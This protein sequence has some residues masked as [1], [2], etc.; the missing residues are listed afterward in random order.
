MIRGARQAS[1]GAARLFRHSRRL[2]SNR[3]RNGVE[4]PGT[5]KQDAD[6]IHERGGEEGPHAGRIPPEV[7]LGMPP[8]PPGQRGGDDDDGENLRFASR[9][10]SRRKYFEELSLEVDRIVKILL[11]D[12]PGFSARQALDEMNLRVSNELVRE[13]LSRIVVSVDSVNRERFPRLA[14]KFFLWAGQQEG[15]HHSTGMYNLVMKVFAQCGEVKAMWRLLEEMTENG[16]SISARTFHLLICTCGQ[17]GLRRRLVERFIKSSSFNYRPF[18][19]SF[20]AILHTLLTI[21]QYSLIEWVHQKMLMEGHSPDVLTYNIVMRAK[22]MLGKLDQFH[23]LLD[24]MG[25]NGLTPDLHTYNILLHVLGKGDKP[26]AALNLLNYMSD[27]GCVP[28]VLHFTNLID[29]LSRAG[30]LEACKYFFDEMMKKGCE[31]DVVCYTVMITGYVAAAEL[32][33][34]QKLFDDMLVRG[35]LPNVY[36]YNTMIRGLCIVGEF[37][38]A[39]SMLKD[40]DLR[41]CT[42]NFSVYST[43]VCRLRNAGKDAEANNV[44]KYMA[45]KGQYLHLLSRFGGYRRC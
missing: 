12:G 21:E 13:V 16:L 33:E 4:G 36:T 17:A 20:N 14:Y 26:L 41:G 29:G 25:K 6:G 1:P 31:P 45:N 22:Y 30:N 39:C 42:P 32:E 35:K 28:S 40:M 9:Y 19:N 8:P 23:R 44:I 7:L 18:R 5:G 2:C 3:S 15:Y 27:V 37:D 10:R 38:K 11:Q 24:E 43:L 34:A